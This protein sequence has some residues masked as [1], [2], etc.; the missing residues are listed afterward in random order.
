MGLLAGGS[1]REHTRLELRSSETV[2][3]PKR[4]GLVMN[5]GSSEASLQPGARLSNGGVVLTAA[6]GRPGATERFVPIS[7]A[8]FCSQD[9]DDSSEELLG[10]LVVR[11]HRTII[12]GPTG[13]GKTTF[14]YQALHAISAGEPFLDWQGCGECRILIIDLEQSKRSLGKTLRERG[15]DTQRDVYLFRSA[16]GLALDKDADDIAG[17]ESMLRRGGYDVVVV[18]PLYKM[19]TGDSNEE[20]AAVDLMRRLDAWREEYAFALI[21]ASHCRKPTG[22]FSPTTNEVFGSSAFTRGAEVVVYLRMVRP[23]VS[24]L[25]FLKDR[26]G[27][28]EGGKPWKLSFNRENG[29]ERDAA[30]EV[31]KLVEQVAAALRERPGQTKSE[32]QETVGGSIS[33]IEKA[34]RTLGAVSEHGPGRAYR[35]ALNESGTG[36]PA[37]RTMV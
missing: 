28:L 15:L 18:D 14:T 29:F 32:L 26:D 7:A 16:D 1:M 12:A 34:L 13:E 19:H 4:T 33:S 27:E 22:H 25:H 10:P 9:F 35:Y 37:G 17:V 2:E 21:L 11:G 5:A 31:P 24:R 8:E 36:S 6:F 20:R 30:I 3:T 23:G